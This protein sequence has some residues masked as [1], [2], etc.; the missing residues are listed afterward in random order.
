MSVWLAIPS[1]RPVAEVNA[2]MGKWRAM[3]YKIALWRDAEDVP[4][5]AIFTSSCDLRYTLIP[6]CDVLFQSR[7]PG[8]SQAVNHMVRDIFNRDKSCDWIVAAG[9]DTD[10]DPNV[11]ADEIATECSRHFGKPVD[12]SGT[13]FDNAYLP[14]TFGVMQ[15]T[16]DPWS[17]H[18]GRIIE[19]IAG[20]PW[21]GREWCR[22]AYGGRGPLWPEYTHCFAD[23]HLQNVAKALGIFWQRPDLTHYH[24]H[25]SRPKQ[26]QPTPRA[27]DVPDFLQEACSQKHWIESRAIFERQKAGGFAEAYDLLP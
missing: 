24:D 10:P 9:D 20:S 22:R 6:Q 14:G 11:R 21:L 25:W 18:Q 16:G 1:A 3:G 17:D 23:E 2:R 5:G 27:E 26:G 13:S 8:Y 7:Y 19:R 12:C 15:P 4:D